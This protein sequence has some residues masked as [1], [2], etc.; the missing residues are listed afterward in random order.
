VPAVAHGDHPQTINT[1]DGRALC[2]ELAGEPSGRPVL[3]CNGTPNS[4]HLYTPW[5]DDARR[6]GIRLIGY[7]RPGYGGST[8]HPGHTVADGARDVETIADAL[9]IDRLAVWGVSGGGPYALAC[10]ALLPERVVAACALGSIAPWGAPGLDYLS[11]MGQENVDDFKL[12]FV[13][14][15][16]ARAKTER[17]REELLSITPQQLM[18]SW[19]TLVSAV[20]AAAVSGAFADWLVSS[21]Q[22]GLRPGAQGWW[23]DGVA[24]LSPWGF[25]LD[26]IRVPVKVWHGR[27]DRFVPFQHGRWLAEHVPRAEAALSDTDGHLTLLVDI[28]GVHEWLLAHF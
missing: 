18:T 14:P 5:I 19:P 13:D 17:D 11:G 27:E 26:S 21:M 24:H 6:R 4:R 28:S 23:D 10:A 25:E 12:Y 8:P 20:D 16:A 7:D 9:G 22:D 2:V 15:A 3:V 1:L